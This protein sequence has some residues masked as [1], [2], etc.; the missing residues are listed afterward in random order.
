MISN[1]F[2]EVDRRSEQ[3]R[4]KFGS[5]PFERILGENLHSPT[6]VFNFI[7][8]P[9]EKI[10]SSPP[11]ATATASSQGTVPTCTSHAVG[12]AVVELLHFKWHEC[13]QEAVIASLINLKQTTFARQW[14]HVF[15]D[16][17]LALQVWDSDDEESKDWTNIKIG[18]FQSENK[19]PSEKKA[20]SYL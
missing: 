6:A 9:P 16:V 5:K 20:A 7:I 17:T 19:E 14:P 2:L 8:S 18:V 13:N 1:W 15:N 4:E 10:P 11:G 3:S 12:K